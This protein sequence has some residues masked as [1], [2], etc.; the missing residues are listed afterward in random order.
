[1]A[2]RDPG[3]IRPITRRGNDWTN[4]YPLVAEAVNHLKVR[5]CLIDGEVMCCDE[6]GVS[7]FHVLRWRRNEPEPFLY[8][9]VRRILWG[10]CCQQPAPD[11]ATESEPAP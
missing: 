2:R 7:A 3:G 8:A 6:R 1:M 10:D 5:S 9:F 4:R 11:I